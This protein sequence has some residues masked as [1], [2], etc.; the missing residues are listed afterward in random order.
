MLIRKMRFVGKTVFYGHDGMKGGGKEGGGLS[1]RCQEAEVQPCKIRV[2]ER[3]IH[4]TEYDQGSSGVT[5][6]HFNIVK[7]RRVSRI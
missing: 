6:Q 1:F 4:S 7:P 3:K 5:L 2:S